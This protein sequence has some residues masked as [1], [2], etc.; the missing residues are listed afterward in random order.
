MIRRNEVDPELSVY[1]AFTYYAITIFKFLT[2]LIMDGKLT[3]FR[4]D[5]PMCWKMP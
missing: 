4:Y 1:R 2:L 5:S 3:R